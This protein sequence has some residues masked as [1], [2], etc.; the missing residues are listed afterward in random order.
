[1]YVKELYYQQYYTPLSNQLLTKIITNLL[2]EYLLEYIY[3]VFIT[4][5][6]ISC[7]SRLLLNACVDRVAFDSMKRIYIYRSLQRKT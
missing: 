4:T 3:I 5:S 6:S 1:M 7:L 2:V